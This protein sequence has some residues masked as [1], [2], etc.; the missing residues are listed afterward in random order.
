MRCTYL[1]SAKNKREL[2]FY[3]VLVPKS[4]ATQ[5]DEGYGKEFVNASGNVYNLL[6]KQEKKW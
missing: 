5:L 4:I 6:D 1:L 2:P 3:Q